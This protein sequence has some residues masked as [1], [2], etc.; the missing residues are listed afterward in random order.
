[1]WPGV[2]P[3]AKG[4]IMPD[5]TG[6]REGLDTALSN[7]AA[8]I[9]KFVGFLLILIVGYIVAK[10][11][12]KIVDAVLERVGFDRAV[13]RGGVKQ[14]LA[15]SNYDA[16][17]LVAKVVFYTVFL[18]ALQMAFGVFGANP[19]SDLLTSVV[20]YLPKVFAA[21]LII[22]VAAAIAAGVKEIVEAS[23]G[24]LS[25]GR[26]LS[27]AASAT[28][29]TIGAFAALNQLQIAAPIVNGLFYAALAI[30]V[31]SAVI[32]IGGGGITPMRAQWEKALAKIEEEG[33]QVRQ[34][35]Q[36][37]G[38]RVEQRAEQRKEQVADLRD[39]PQRSETPGYAGSRTGTREGDSN[40]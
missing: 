25:Y 3:S 12:A 9:P 7:T 10:V 38:Q 37:A 11:I 19:V 23:L 33:P 27:L 14:A 40:R 35:A 13:E 24:G 1:M 18:L 16:S 2:T 5:A 28:I 6:F 32:A 22:V 29:V 34:E 26:A 30:I 39:E 20:A 15:K 31:G 21:I 4:I 8:F 36:G 17:T